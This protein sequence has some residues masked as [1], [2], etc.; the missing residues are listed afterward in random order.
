ML[1][2][3]TTPV[4]IQDDLFKAINGEWLKTHE[5]PADRASDGAFNQLRDQAEEHVRTIIEG[6]NPDDDGEAGKIGRLYAA[7]MDTAT[8]ESLGLAP[9]H[10]ALAGIARATS[11]K[12]L[13]MELGRLAPQGGPAVVD[14]GVEADMN[15]PDRYAL[16]FSQA[17]IALPDESYYHAEEHA[18]I[19]TAYLKHLER[20]VELG[21]LLPALTDE[22][23]AQQAAAQIMAVETA[24]AKGHRDR[25]AARDIE[26]MNNPVTFA[27]LTDLYG[28]FPLPQWTEAA[29]LQP[30]HLDVLICMVPEFCENL[31][32]VW[33]ATEL[34]DLKLWAGWHMLH[35]LAPYLPAAIVE[36]NFSMY[37]R[38]LTGA[39]ELRERWKRGVGVVEGAL[40]EAVGKLYVAEHFPPTHKA[41]M[42][43]LVAN[44]IEAYHQ[45]I[46][47][48]EWMTPQTRQ[49]ALEKLASFRPKVGYPNRWRDYSALDIPAGDLVG[50]IANS[51]R[52]NTARQ[53][54]KLGGPIDR[55][56]WF[57][58]PQTVNAYYHPIMNEIVFPAAILQA[59]FF[60][61]DADEATNYG[62]IGAVIGH[63]I[64]HGFDDQGSL[65]DGRGQVSNWWTDEDREEFKKRTASLIEQY[66]AF[67]PS[68]LPADT[69][70]H[71]NGALTIGENIGDLGGLTIGLK[72][73]RIALDKQG[74]SLTESVDGAPSPLQQIF[75]SWATIWREKS[76]D[77]AII[78]Q[79]TIDPH[80]PCEF[81]CNGVPRN[82]DA[83]YDAFDVREGDGMWLDP[84][85]RVTIW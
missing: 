61:I 19:R 85:K 77:E 12:D 16:Y 75:Y 4:R 60:D 20:M 55:D 35:S 64:G 45:S 57:M 63:E 71:V 58:T 41:A 7:F 79:V 46:S 68:Q 73:L 2:I 65:F 40:G 36:E 8:I 49:K 28:H 26:A 54:A 44:L 70:H 14:L 31:S 76:R 48:L 21:E 30:H 23:T 43:E 53:L 80:S 56:E 74:K 33:E 52:F 3:M 81:R 51:R 39:T 32:R 9:L 69:P 84:D 18:Q 29:G 78:Q 83:F 38:T 13:A 27:E 82:M 17:G 34:A 72:A 1:G 42:D 11:K 24:I 67:V 37:G 62:G 10:T 47:T 22:R 6:C 15:D 25:V 59:P 5:I 50:A 66:D